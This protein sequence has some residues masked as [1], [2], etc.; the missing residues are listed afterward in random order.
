MEKT[1]WLNA[2]SSIFLNFHHFID[3]IQSIDCFG[4]EKK[5]QILTKW[6]VLCEFAMW[7]SVY[8]CVC[9]GWCIITYIKWIIF[10]SCSRQSSA[11]EIYMYST[12]RSCDLYWLKFTETVHKSW[13]SRFDHICAIW[14][15]FIHIKQSTRSYRC[16]W[17]NEENVR[18][19]ETVH[20]HTNTHRHDRALMA[21][22]LT[23][24][25]S[26]FIFFLKW[27]RNEPILRFANCIFQESRI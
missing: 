1:T 20:T 22:D 8:V 6:I 11:N 10:I 24:F 19:G 2:N 26:L 21:N 9:V 12:R 23:L 17:L 16:W 7:M 3:T 18:W 5:S 15:C 27:N 4:G 25:F 14:N 13:W